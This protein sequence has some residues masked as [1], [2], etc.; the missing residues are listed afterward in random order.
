MDTQKIVKRTGYVFFLPIVAPFMM[1]KRAVQGL[2]Q[3]VVLMFSFPKMLIKV[4]RDVR[5]GKGRKEIRNFEELLN[6]WGLKNEAQIA[7]MKAEFVINL[8]SWFVLLVFGCVMAVL[9]PKTWRAGLSLVLMWTVG[10]T[11]VVMTGW[12]LDQLISREVITFSN[13]LKF[14][15]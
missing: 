3:L 13:W 6:A 4:F 1:V 7:E 14:W 2:G 12:R 15:R 9:G 11:G 10:M 8:I 5:E